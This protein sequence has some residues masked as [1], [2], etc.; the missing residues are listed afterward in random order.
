M[1]KFCKVHKLGNFPIYHF[2][3]NNQ[4]KMCMAFMR[5]VEFDCKYFKVN[6]FIG[7]Y[8]DK[9]GKFDY[10]DLNVGFTIPSLEMYKFYKVFKRSLSKDEKWIF[11]KLKRLNINNKYS[12]IVTLK[13]DLETIR[14]E[15]VHAHYDLYEN[16]RKDVN[17]VIRKFGLRNIKNALREQGYMKRD[18]IE[19]INSYVITGL[20]PKMKKTIEIK[21]LKANLT[22]V[23]KK[24][25][26]AM[27]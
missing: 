19:E 24:H 27:I 18:F 20:L 14:H 15:L 10:M 26:N 12:I 4:H 1:N 16:Y 8:I 11:N 5:I 22:S 23:F 21:K 25:F 9:H 3:F 7:D 2:E 6:D 13:N 17:K